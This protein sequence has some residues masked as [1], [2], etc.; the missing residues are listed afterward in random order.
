MRDPVGDFGYDIC[1]FDGNQA[2]NLTTLDT[3]ILAGKK[4]WVYQANFIL[5]ILD[6]LHYNI[7]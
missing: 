3:L 4:R 2:Y 1:Q 6:S 5:A 7:W